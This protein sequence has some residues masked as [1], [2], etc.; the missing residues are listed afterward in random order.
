MPPLKAAFAK[1]LQL[2][3]AA[4]PNPAV[5]TLIALGL[6]WI[7]FVHLVPSL[8]SGL[9]V[10]KRILADGWPQQ[11]AAV[12]TPLS[13]WDARWYFTIASD[14]YSFAGTKNESTVRFYPLYPMLMAATKWATGI[15]LLWAGTLVSA[16]ALLVVLVLLVGR[17][18]AETGDEAG[19]TTVEAILFFPSAFVLA[20]VYAESIGLLA[21]LLSTV[22]ARRGRWLAAGL[23]GAL[24]GMSRVNGCLVLLPLLVLAPGAWR[25]GRR[26]RP[27]IALVLAALG[28]AAF[29]AYLWRKFGDPFLYFH[30]RPAAWPQNPRFFALYLW[31]IG[32]A[33]VSFIQMGYVPKGVQGMTSN[34]FPVNVGVL[35]LMFWTLAAS[36]RKRKWDDAAFMAGACLFAT[37]VGSLD[38]LARHSLIYFPMYLRLGETAA[39]HRTFRL[40]MCLVF[41]STQAVLLTLF[42]RW[43]FVL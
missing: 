40:G 22:L 37:S 39:A 16:L 24:A 23:A 21:I 2:T 9:L 29:P 26:W 41:L 8:S 33:M 10:D 7:C 13:R 42:V 34:M 1:L 17:A 11:M 14:G 12:Q 28:A 3:R 31:D 20:S 15:S 18:R 36:V 38:S 43:I 32:K 35:I 6:F 30:T 25:A 5:R 4:Q 19:M 27:G